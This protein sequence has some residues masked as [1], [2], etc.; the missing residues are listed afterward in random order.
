V[1]HVC[2]HRLL[3]VGEAEAVDQFHLLEHCAFAGL[4][5]A[6]TQQHTRHSTSRSH[7]KTQNTPLQKRW[8]S[9]L[10]PKSTRQLNTAGAV[11]VTAKLH[12]SGG[13]SRNQRTKQ[14]QLDLLILPLPIFSVL[15]VNLLRKALRF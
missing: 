11:L 5:W 12:K 15:L 7:G 13:R 2:K 10:R 3:L 9:A 1:Y 4:P 14:E 8:C 6:C